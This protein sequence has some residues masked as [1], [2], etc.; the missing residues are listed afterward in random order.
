MNIYSSGPEM[1]APRIEGNRFNANDAGSGAGSGGALYLGSYVSPTVVGNTFIGNQAYNGGAI[2]LHSLHAESAELRGNTFQGNSASGYGG[3]LHYQGST[4]ST[5]VVSANGFF[6]NDAMLAGAMFLAGDTGGLIS[7]RGNDAGGNSA[8]DGG[9]FGWLE[10]GHVISTNN[11]VGGNHAGFRGAAWY[12]N[13]GT[14]QARN[15][16]IVENQGAPSAVDAHDSAVVDLANCILWNPALTSDVEHA[17]SITYSCLH[18]TAAATKGNTLGAGVIFADPK[19]AAPG[20]HTIDLAATVTMY[21]R[22]EQRGRPVSRLLRH[23]PSDRRRRQRCR[24]SRH[25]SVRE[26]DRYRSDVPGAVDQRVRFGNGDRNAQDQGRVGLVGRPVTIE[27]SYDN[28]ATVA[29]SKTA[30]TAVAGAYS[31]SFGPTRKTYYRA[32][33][34]GD[35]TRLASNQVSRVVLPRVY[36]TRPKAASPMRYRKSYSVSGYLKPR[37]TSGTKPVRIMLYRRKGGHYVLQKKHYHAT[38]KNYSTYSKYSVRIKL[39]YRGKWRLKAYHP[40]DSLNAS[41]KSGYRYVTV[42]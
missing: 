11:A 17:D 34:A 8:S 15:D 41:T 19:F 29:G 30:V 38:V 13:G 4:N 18:D 5:L 28:W 25:R 42:K 2:F 33:Y 24:Q 23:A 1:L 37:H 12:L 20:S 36:L 9:G 21:R 3:G 14:F 27:Y 16:T 26:E 32:R 7:V 22:R 31:A 40:T 10:A 39:P 35:S 6:D